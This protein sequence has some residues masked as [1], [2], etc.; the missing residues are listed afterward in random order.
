MPQQHSPDHPRRV[1]IVDSDEDTR[2]KYRRPLQDGGCDVIEASDGRDALAKALI[3]PPAAIVT[4]LRLAFVDGVALCGI[5]RQDHV[6]ATV[7]IVVVTDEARQIRSDRAK[8]A[9]ADVVLFKPTTADALLREI[10]RLTEAVAPESSNG[11]RVRAEPARSSGQGRL[12]KVRAHTRFA[13][14]TPPKLPPALTCP[15]CDRPLTYESSQIGGVSS[16]HSEQWDYFTCSSCGVFRYRQRTRKLQ[17]LSDDEQ[18]WVSRL[19][20]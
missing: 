18:Q 19:R 16:L 3:R 8:E 20:A 1:L 10:D 4:E 6:T 7:P 12:P 13:T 17:R 9:G 11:G 15:L 5:L 2:A 14:T